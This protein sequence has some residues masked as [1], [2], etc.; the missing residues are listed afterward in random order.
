VVGREGTVKKREEGGRG[1]KGVK[2][3]V[4]T[5]TT[6]WYKD[7]IKWCSCNEDMRRSAR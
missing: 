6:A 3:E 7:I 1:E 2:I 4:G 5:I